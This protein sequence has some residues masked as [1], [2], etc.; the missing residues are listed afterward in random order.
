MTEECLKYIQGQ[1]LSDLTEILLVDNG[2][3]PPLMLKTQDSR[4]RIVRLDRNRSNI[5]GQ[6][7]CFENAS[8]ENILFVSN[9]VKMLAGSITNL[10]GHAGTLLEYGQIQPVF[11]RTDG[12]VDNAGLMYAWPGYGVSRPIVTCCFHSV[13]IVPSIAY[14]MRKSVWKRMGGFDETL[15]SAYEDVDMGLRLNKM[16]LKNYVCGCSAAVHVGNATLRDLPGVRERFHRARRQVIRK[17]FKGLN[18][19]SR[20]AAE[21]FGY[22]VSAVNSL[23]EIPAHAIGVVSKPGRSGDGLHED[24]VR[25]APA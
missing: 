2:S 3:N 5:G 24:S 20:L 8:N 11:F 14:L 12:L 18:R 6:N 21:S 9:D 25:N 15:P 13:R 4:L 16:G 23:R 22:M 17:H 19:T 1:W 10:Y 7:A